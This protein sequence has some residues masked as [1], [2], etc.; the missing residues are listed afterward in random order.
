MT[1]NL[2]KK[3]RKRRGDEFFDNFKEVLKY[4][5]NKDNKIDLLIHGG[6]LFFRSK[7]HPLISDITY[8]LLLDF[9]E[10]TKIPIVIIPGNHERSILPYSLLT[11]HRDIHIFTKPDNFLLQ[12]SNKNNIILSISAFPNVRENLTD[13]FNNIV[14][15]EI[16]P[17]EKKNI[18]LYNNEK[19]VDIKI[20]CMHQSIENS[21]VHN[22]TFKYGH[23][24]VKMKDLE[25]LDYDCILSGHIHRYQV[26]NVR[27]DKDKNDT[28]IIYSGSTQ[29]TSFQERFEDK[30]FCILNFEEPHKDCSQK[31]S[32]KLKMLKD[33]SF[34]KLYSRDMVQIKVSLNNLENTSPK[35]L[36]NDFKKYLENKI[37]SIKK[38]SIV[39][40]EVSDDILKKYLTTKF[41]NSIFPKTMNIDFSINYRRKKNN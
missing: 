10:E 38:D 19:K 31:D 21:K 1:R 36:N 41:I 35:S 14:K 16:I 8:N 20:L 2:T 34:I 5:K 40:L 11:Q 6:D 22:Y 32:E 17:L 12:V 27:S 39:K 4:A 37:K 15:N 33:I 26:Y 25:N 28:P 23:D 13:K 3:K 24:I 30:G 7:I 9:V 29:R 18:G